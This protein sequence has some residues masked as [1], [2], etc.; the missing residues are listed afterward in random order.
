MFQFQQGSIITKMLG[1]VPISAGSFQFQ[2]GSIITDTTYVE[3][4]LKISFNS[5]KVQL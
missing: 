1:N 2:Q 5:N 4:L 3:I